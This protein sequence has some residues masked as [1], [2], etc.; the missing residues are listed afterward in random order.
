MNSINE[1]R[2]HPRYQPPPLQVMVRS[3][4]ASDNDWLA[5]RLRAVDFN[6]HG[7]ALETDFPLLAGDQLNLLLDGGDERSARLVAEVRNRRRTE[8]GAYRF[9]LVFDYDQAADPSAAHEMLM[10][11]LRAVSK[12]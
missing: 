10:L 4:D 11:E 7:M 8:T 12:R 5:G 3:L 2:Q 6:R 1:R 9:G